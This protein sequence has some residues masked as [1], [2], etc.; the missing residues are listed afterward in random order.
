MT[1]PL[2]YLVVVLDTERARTFGIVGCLGCV[3]YE[4]DDGKCSVLIKDTDGGLCGPFE[5]DKSDFEI[6][7]DE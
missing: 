4:Y 7:E 2:P 1:S 6:R 3:E 5:L